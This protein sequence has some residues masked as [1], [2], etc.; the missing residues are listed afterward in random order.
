MPRLLT[1]S[2]MAAA[3]RRTIEELGLPGIVLME[4]AG[5]GVVKVLRR[6]LPDLAQR[7]VV[8]V[9]GLGNNGG[10]GF[11]I[12]RHL[13]Q[14]GVAVQV[15]LLGAAEHQ[16]GDALINFRVFHNLGG[17]V[18]RVWKADDLATLPGALKHAG[19]VVDALFGTGLQRPVGG[20]F[21]EAIAMINRSGKPVLAV[22]LPSGV[23][24]DTGQI[25][26]VAVRA[27]W[28]VTFAAEKI[29]H[30]THPGAALCGKVAC[31]PIGI[32][33]A[34]LDIAEHAVALNLP[35]DLTIPA[36]PVDGHKGRFGHLLI[37]AG[38]RGKTGA[39][40]LTT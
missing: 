1:A 32:P 16:Q 22:D 6:E 14:A 7:R 18:R 30:R 38:S 31:V 40:L 10:D 13:L 17:V 2:Q 15:F 34:Y 23:S 12:A 9:A 37:L 19:V 24:A 20:L 11:V 3:D 33:D 21:A 26:G 25:L 36:R 35:D 29:G 28:T 39:A 8:V 4:N 5:A 27:D